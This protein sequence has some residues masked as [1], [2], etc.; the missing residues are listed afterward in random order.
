MR[1]A[2]LREADR[3]AIGQFC[4]GG[5]HEPIVLRHIAGIQRRQRTARQ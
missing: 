5:D 4:R 3:L 1:Q 2:E